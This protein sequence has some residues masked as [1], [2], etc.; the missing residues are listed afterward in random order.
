MG[1]TVASFKAFFALSRRVL[2]SPH[3]AS[4]IEVAQRVVTAQA[5]QQQREGAM[6]QPARDA[7]QL[8]DNTQV[9]KR[10]AM[11]CG[12]DVWCPIDT[13][14]GGCDLIFHRLQQQTTNGQRAFASAS[15][16][17][18]LVMLEEAA[19]LGLDTEGS[20][21]FSKVWVRAAAEDKGAAWSTLVKQVLPDIPF[22]QSARFSRSTS[23]PLP[24]PKPATHHGR[25]PEAK[26]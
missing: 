5:E 14:N 19:V 18:E 22:L 12:W 11:A 13:F 10:V 8:R 21:H 2:F 17:S 1:R 9:W 15:V 26:P 6:L 24:L 16:W 3:T 4:S 20:T 25:S 23:H 7:G